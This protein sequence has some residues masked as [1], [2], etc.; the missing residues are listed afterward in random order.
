MRKALISILVSIVLILGLMLGEMVWRGLNVVNCREWQT[1]LQGRVESYARLHLPDPAPQVQVQSSCGHSFVADALYFRW[2]KLLWRMGWREVKPLD[3]AELRMAATRD[4]MQHPDM[5]TLKF[6]VRFDAA[7]TADIRKSVEGLVSRYLQVNEPRQKLEFRR[8]KKLPDQP[9]A[10]G[11]T[12]SLAAPPVKARRF[13]PPLYP[14]PEP[15][16]SR[17]FVK[18]SNTII[19][20]LLACAVGL[21]LLQIL[22]QWLKP[23]QKQTAAPAAGIGE[24]PAYGILVAPRVIQGF[25]E[26]GREVWRLLLQQDRERAGSRILQYWEKDREGLLHFLGWLDTATQESMLSFL[27]T[28][29]LLQLSDH[30]QTASQPRDAQRAALRV[31]LDLA[32]ELGQCSQLAAAPLFVHLMTKREWQRVA[33]QLTRPRRRAMAELLDKERASWLRG[34][35]DLHPGWFQNGNKEHMSIEQILRRIRSTLQTDADQLRDQLSSDREAMQVVDSYFADLTLDAALNSDL[36]MLA[37]GSCL[38]RHAGFGRLVERQDPYLQV[39]LENFDD[40]QVALLLYECEA[41]VRDLLLGSLGSRSGIVRILLRAMEEDKQHGKSLRLQARSLQ[42][43][44]ERQ[45]LVADLLCA[46]DKAW[47]PS[48]NP[49]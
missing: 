37:L 44:V 48:E 33:Q 24:K 7:L 20:I 26:R 16:V 41:S 11:S 36:M 30:V 39:A 49:G 43:F 28:D 29:Q 42:R 27:E 12:L 19:A 3:A 40:Q 47:S 10:H 38:H 25:G 46:G 31:L 18:S 8:V 45:V 21:L 9:A 17:V 35:Q 1:E 4:L 15:A 34:R 22:R 6:I 14:A 2:H 32:R 5:G 13:H 23:R